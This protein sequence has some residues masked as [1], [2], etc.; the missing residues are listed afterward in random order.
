MRIY[1][2][3]FGRNPPFYRFLRTLQAYETVLDEKTT[4]FLPA[5]AEIFTILQGDRASSAEPGIGAGVARARD[6]RSR[7]RRA[8][9]AAARRGRGPAPAAPAGEAV[10]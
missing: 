9:R 8:R 1:A 5:E 2:D 10:P 6:R 7:R 3:A 4:L